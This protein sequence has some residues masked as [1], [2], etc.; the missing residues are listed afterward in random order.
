MEDLGGVTA[1]DP[2][3]GDAMA[4]GARGSAAG[5]DDESGATAGDGAA[6]YAALMR[7]PRIAALVGAVATLATAATNLFVL[8]DMSGL[9]W[10]A[11]V[12]SAVICVL[13]ITN[14]VNHP[15]R[16]VDRLRQLAAQMGGRFSLWK[17]GTGGNLGV[18]FAHGAEHERFGVVS[19]E[20][21]GM[22]IEMGTLASQVSTR[23]RAPTGRRHAYVTIHLPE[24]LPHMIMSFGHLS[25][26]L[27]VRVAPEQ[28][29]RSQRVDV[30]GDGRFRLFVAD[31]GEAAA[32]AFFRPEVVAL[33]ERIGRDYDVEIRDRRL[34]LFPGRSPAAGSERRWAAQRQELETFTGALAGSGVWEAVGRQGRRLRDVQLHADVR[35]AVT[36]VF[37]VVAVVVVVV[38]VV[39]LALTG[40][41]G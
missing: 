41:I 12:S 9:L 23:Y 19:G 26:V 3:G 6:R 29:H 14:M 39:W 34:Y 10:V 4:D 32:R 40:R 1:S 11:T 2:K 30:G 24:R 33:F 36:L 25:R 8:E 22:P 27:G 18:P 35:R 7:T 37:S 20:L 21:H 31:G 15:P 17:A 28:W 16:A 38:S 13:A 5:R